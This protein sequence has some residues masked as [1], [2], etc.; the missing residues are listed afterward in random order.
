MLLNVREKIKK[1]LSSQL[2][3]SFCCIYCLLAQQFIIQSLEFVVDLRTLFSLWISA[4]CNQDWGFSFS[5]ATGSSLSW[6]NLYLSKNQAL[7]DFFPRRMQWGYSDFNQVNNLSV[8]G[9]IIYSLIQQILV[10][11]LLCRHIL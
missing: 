2:A 8:I 7:Y 10:K 5:A 4:C 6:G 11:C 3:T 1:N 9:L